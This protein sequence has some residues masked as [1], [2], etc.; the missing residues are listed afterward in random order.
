MNS[1][2]DFSIVD[3]NEKAVELYKKNELAKIHLMPLEFGG[4]DILQNTL[5][6]P[7]FAKE[8]KERFDSMIKDFLLQG[9]KLTYSASPEYKGENFIPSRLIIKVNGYVSFE[10]VIVEIW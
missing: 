6:A 9:K 7:R 8:F 5:Y 1:A 2:P 10:E 4:E 3:S